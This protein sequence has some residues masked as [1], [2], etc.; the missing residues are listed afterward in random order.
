MKNKIR[1]VIFRGKKNRQF[2]FRIVSRNGKTV[3]QSEGYKR[4][5]SARQAINAITTGIADGSYS[6]EER[7]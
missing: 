3:A 6:I 5:A 7:E 2:Y 4:R 1:F